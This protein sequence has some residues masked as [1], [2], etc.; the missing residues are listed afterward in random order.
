MY[1]SILMYTYRTLRQPPGGRPGQTE[2]LAPLRRGCAAWSWLLPAPNRCPYIAHARARASDLW[3]LM[4][5][6][7]E[8]FRQAY[9][10]RLHDAVPL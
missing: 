9:D 4:D 3:R 1:I 5:Q 2:E 7:F 6:H 8:T 10:E